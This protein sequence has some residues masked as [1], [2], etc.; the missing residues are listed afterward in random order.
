MEQVYRI[1]DFNISICKAFRT[2]VF[3]FPNKSLNFPNCIFTGVSKISNY[4]I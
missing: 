3:E 4:L 2:R 1:E